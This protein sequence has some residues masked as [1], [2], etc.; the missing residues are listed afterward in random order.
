MSRPA[1]GRDAT[2]RGGLP[3]RRGKRSPGTGCN[4]CQ[5]AGPCAQWRWQVGVRGRGGP[6]TARGPPTGPRR[7]RCPTESRTRPS[8]TSASSPA[9]RRRRSNCDSTPPRLVAWAQSRGAVD[10][11]APRSRASASSI[12]SSE[13]KPAIVRAATSWPGSFAQPGITHPPHRGMA[14]SRSARTQCAR[15][16]LARAAA[17]ACGA[18]AAPGR[19]PSARGWRRCRGARPVERGVLSV[20]AEAADQRPE[21][22]VGVP[23]DELG[24]RVQHDVG[25][26]LERPLQQRGG[27]GVVHHEPD[28][29]RAAPRRSRAGPR[30]RSSGWSATPARPGRR[31][32]PR[33][34]PRPCRRRPPG[35]RSSRTSRPAR[36]PAR[37][38]PQ[39]AVRRQ[40]HRPRPAT[41]LQHG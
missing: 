40:H 39:I 28:P 5:A 25:A 19:P 29:A 26:E 23:G 16:G 41:Q 7:A 27:E 20:V 10:D 37:R 34:V 12:A 17:P 22:G 9:Q 38:D 4:L 32:R 30:P 36:S 33:P 15:V 8:G 14:A 2:E 31:P 18:R 11:S 35:A 1:P 6:G 13:P 21:Q 3:R 24:R